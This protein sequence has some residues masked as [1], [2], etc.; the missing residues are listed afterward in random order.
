[1]MERI[2]SCF[3]PEA[4]SR[5]DFESVNHPEIHVVDWK[6]HDTENGCSPPRGVKVHGCKQAIKGVCLRNLPPLDVSFCLFGENSLLTGDPS[7]Q[8]LQCEC[9]ATPKPLASE[10]WI[11]VI[12]TKYSDDLGEEQKKDEKKESVKR[13]NLLELAY[14]AVDQIMV[15]VEYLRN[16][17]VIES[18]RR[19]NA[20]VTFPSLAEDFNAWLFSWLDVEDLVVTKKIKIN[21]S[22]TATIHSTKRIKFVETK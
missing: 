6:K 3:P 20:I 9:V 14:L 11:L 18:N 12:E 5:L 21:I 22:N 13:K 4:I 15:T 1:M 7:G 2:R 8:S 10:N 16:R 17:A 19:V